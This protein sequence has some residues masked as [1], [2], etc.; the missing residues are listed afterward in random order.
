MSIS[1]Q[2]V[3]D[4]ARSYVGTPFVD[5][6]RSKGRGTDCVGLPLMVAGDLG[7]CDTAGLPLTGQTY[8]AYSSQPVTNIVLDLC[9]KH[10]VRI[11]LP[12]KQPGDVLVMKV[13]HAPCHV[14][15]YAGKVG[16]LPTLIHAY[17]GAGKCVEHNID[18]RWDRRIVAAFR[19]PG[20]E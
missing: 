10:L 16:G 19:F 20:V 1:P 17:S 8:T 9:N 6:G 13:P 12:D 3:V 4:C 11:P 7:V 14:G 15:I 18:V 5:K 2:Q